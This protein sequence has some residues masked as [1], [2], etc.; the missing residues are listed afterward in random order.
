MQKCYVSILSSFKIYFKLPSRMSQAPLKSFT[1]NG[2]KFKNLH[3]RL[4]NLFN[5]SNKDHD[6][7]NLSDPF[8]QNFF[9]V[10]NTRSPT[11]ATI[12]EDYDRYVKQDDIFAFKPLVRQI[13]EID[14]EIEKRQC[15]RNPIYTSD[16]DEINDKNAYLEPQLKSI[17]SKETLDQND[18]YEVID[19]NFNDIDFEIKK[20]KSEMQV[21]SLT[22]L[23][24]SKVLMENFLPIVYLEKLWYVHE[25]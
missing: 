4:S 25:S 7:Q 8:K 17:E 21:S 24:K 5:A 3:V 12:F 23:V 15:I 16:E 20:L 1:L 22:V 19:D 2:R 10:K 11:R 14:M 9:S 6:E 18:Y 13:S